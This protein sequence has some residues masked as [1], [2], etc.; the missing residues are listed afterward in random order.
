[1]IPGRKYGTVTGNYHLQF[2]MAKVNG[3][4]IKIS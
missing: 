1:L 3:N 4:S 2:T